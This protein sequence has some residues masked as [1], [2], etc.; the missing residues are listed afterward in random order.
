MSY[1]ERESAQLDILSEFEDSFAL[2]TEVARLRD[3]NRELHIELQ[4]H[5]D[6]LAEARQALID[7][8]NTVDELVALVSAQQQLL[9][10]ESELTTRISRGE[11]A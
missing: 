9:R 11:P 3:L 7:M 10:E 1:D 6:E 4:Q 8:C 2:A 5:I